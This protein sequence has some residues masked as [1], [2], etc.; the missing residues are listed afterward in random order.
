MSRSERGEDGYS[1]NSQ[2][3]VR[4]ALL[5]VLKSIVSQDKCVLEEG[6]G[7]WV[8]LGGNET[9]YTIIFKRKM[10]DFNC[11]LPDSTCIHVQ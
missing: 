7:K 8:G 11:V 9:C 1:D 3:G 2:A 6:R 5:S 4:K 10:F